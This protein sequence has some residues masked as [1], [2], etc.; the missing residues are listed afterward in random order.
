[1]NTQ[2]SCQPKSGQTQPSKGETTSWDWQNSTHDQLQQRGP[3]L[4]AATRLLGNMK[5]VADAV[6]EKFLH[7]SA[8]TSTVTVFENYADSSIV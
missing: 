1:M 4:G 6:L 5:A 7:T 3:P 8:K 2:T